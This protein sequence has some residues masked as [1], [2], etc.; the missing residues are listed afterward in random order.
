MTV[1][2]RVE[3]TETKWIL[4]KFHSKLIDCGMVTQGAQKKVNAFLPCGRGHCSYENADNL[5][6]LSTEK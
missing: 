2:L 5:R 6:R 3:Q 1:M 4:N